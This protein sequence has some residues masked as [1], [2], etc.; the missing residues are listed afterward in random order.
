MLCAVIFDFDGVIADSEALHLRAFNVLL[1]PFGVE[2]STEAYYRD[3]LGLTDFECFTQVVADRHLG[4]DEAAVRDLVARKNR[5]FK[6]FAAT[7]G[8]I[9]D[10]VV[11][12]L[13]LLGDANIPM[14]ICSGAR[15]TEIQQILD[16]AGLGRCFETVVAADDVAKGK[17]DPEGFLLTLEKLNQNRRPPIVSS[18]CVVIEDSHWGLSAAR[19]AEMRTIAV[20]NSYDAAQLTTADLVVARLD[21]L[22]LQQL[23]Q[24]CHSP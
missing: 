3:Y 15:R 10:G 21:T 9:I 14:A 2:I 1:K 17:P 12:F 23:H 11:P 13:S 7:E 5:I 18:Q 8:H 24:L 4:L 16:Q 19:A 22:T 20:T 6:E